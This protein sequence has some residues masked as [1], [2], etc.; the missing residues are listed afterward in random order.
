[1]C[2]LVSLIYQIV[3]FSEGYIVL[4]GRLMILFEFQIQRTPKNGP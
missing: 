4:F 3:S 2:E 1:M